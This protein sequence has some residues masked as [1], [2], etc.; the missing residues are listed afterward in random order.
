LHPD[1]AGP[2]EARVGSIWQANAYAP[3][4]GSEATLQR[5]QARLPFQALMLQ[6]Q[7]RRRSTRSGNS[8]ALEI[9]DT[10]AQ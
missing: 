6:G 10:I 4:I 2:D 8:G 3:M 7:S 9:S 1:F 5:M